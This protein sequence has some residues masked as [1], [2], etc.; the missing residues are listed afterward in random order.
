[1]DLGL[2]CTFLK[3]PINFKTL[4]ATTNAALPRRQGLQRISEVIGHNLLAL[5]SAI[6][7]CVTNNIKSFRVCSFFAPL[8][9]HPKLGY[10]FTELPDWA[11]HKTWFKRVKEKAQGK[12][13]LGFHP[14]QFT[15]LN[16]LSITG[17]E[18]AFRDIEYQC[19]LAELIGATTVNIHGGSTAGGKDNA[20]TRFRDNFHKLSPR[21]QLMLTVEND[22]KAYHVADLLPLCQ[23]LS[24]PL[25]YDVHHHRCLPDSLS[26]EE[27]TE[28]AMATWKTQ[29]PLFHVSSP[30]EGYNSR[31][32]RPHHDYIERVDFP[33]FWLDQDI[34]VEVEAKA[35][36]CAVLQLQYELNRSLVPA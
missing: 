27:A 18:N 10:D 32:S 4:R 6:D 19:E 12:I 22:D 26:I 35:K 3:E 36:E 11:I 13:R 1:M 28:K 33:E 9:A 23:D 15:L 29:K 5:N 17:L 30:R 25:V 20:L 31:D 34:T 24:V 21:A 8:K 16:T 14:D 2:C 7:W